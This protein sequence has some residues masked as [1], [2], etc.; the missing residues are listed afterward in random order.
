[1]NFFQTISTSHPRGALTISVNRSMECMYIAYILYYSRLQLV[2]N[3]FT[4]N[5]VVLNMFSKTHRER[6]TSYKVLSTE[7]LQL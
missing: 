1:M 3:P 2:D 7:S 5:L 4:E 6:I